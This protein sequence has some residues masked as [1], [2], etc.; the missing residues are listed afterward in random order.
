MEG[1]GWSQYEKLVLSQ[2][3]EL[4]QAQKDQARG[5]AELS[6]NV[7]LIAQTV[8][9]SEDY[10]ERL[11][12]LEQT[13]VTEDKLKKERRWILGTAFAV[14]GSIVLPSLY[15]MLSAGVLG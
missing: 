14:L 12:A 3:D 4:R 6:T 11:V 7:A 1:N 2:L 13:S 9:R 10:D 15:V 5:L 8:S